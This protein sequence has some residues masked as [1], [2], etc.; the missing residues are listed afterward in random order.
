M[1]RPM[2]HPPMKIPTD[3][4]PNPPTRVSKET[5]FMAQKVKVHLEDD[6]DGGPAEDAIQFSLDGKDHEIDLSATNAEKLREALRPF[7]DA[8]RKTTRRGGTRNPRSRASNSDPDT[9]KIRAWA[10]EKGFEVSDRGRIHQ[11]VRVAYYAAH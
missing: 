9:A 5:S 8:G 11:S 6:L 7:A 10:K 1:M 2:P 3:P 4:D